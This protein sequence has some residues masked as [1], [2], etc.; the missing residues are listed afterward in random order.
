MTRAMAH[1]ATMGARYG[2]GG[3]RIGPM[4]VLS[5]ASSERFSERYPARNTTRMTFRS[6]DGWPES[7]PTESVSLA[8]LTS[9]PSTNVSARSAMPAAAHVYL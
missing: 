5:S 9:L 2:I 7:G 6:S 8:P 1:I 4:R 3:R